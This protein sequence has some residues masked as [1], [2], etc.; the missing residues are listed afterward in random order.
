M[1]FFS[2]LLVSF[3]QLHHLVSLSFSW[4]LHNGNKLLVSSGNFLL[5]DNDLFF[6]LHDFDFNLFLT[7]LLLLF[8]C[9]QLICQLSFSFLQTLKTK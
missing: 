3:S 1:Y 2:H 8:S 6:P 7:D 5:L 4:P 9:L